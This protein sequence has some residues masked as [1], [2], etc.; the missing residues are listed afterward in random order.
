VE[1]TIDE[2]VKTTNHNNWDFEPVNVDE[3]I[4]VL[5]DLKINTAP[6]KDGISNVLLKNISI[7]L[8]N[9]LN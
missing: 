1:K 6:G 3:V 7:N 8:T 2:F 4:D 9:K 5:K